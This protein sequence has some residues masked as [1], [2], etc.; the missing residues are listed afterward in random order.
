MYGRLGS[1]YLL[2]LTEAGAQRHR[3]TDGYPGAQSVAPGM[4]VAMF[5]RL[6]AVLGVGFCA[7]GVLAIMV[8]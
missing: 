4:S 2:H 7:I 1:I 8:A 5:L 6:A 3:L